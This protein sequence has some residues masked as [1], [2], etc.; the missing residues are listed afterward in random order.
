MAKPK[1]K[2]LRK[3][4]TSALA[5]E[6]ATHHSSA[7]GQSLEKREQLQTSAERFSVQESVNKEAIAPS[8]PITKLAKEPAIVELEPIAKSVEKQQPEVAGPIA[9]VAHQP[10]V[11]QPVAPTR[12]AQLQQAIE[13]KLMTFDQLAQEIG[14]QPHQDWTFK[15]PIS[16][17]T[18]T[19]RQRSTAY[20]EVETKLT[21]L[22]ATIDN[23]GKTGLSAFAANRPA[24]EKLLNDQLDE[25]SQA[26]NAYRAA[27]AKSTTKTTAIDN[28][29]KSIGDYKAMLKDGVDAVLADPSFD[30]VKDHINLEQ[31]LNAKKSGINFA[32]CKFDQY[33]DKKAAGADDKF[34]SGV[35]NSVAKIEYKSGESLVFK[36]EKT[37]ETFFE[38]LPIARDVGIDHNAPHYGN[39]NIASSAVADLL[40]SSVMPK[41]SYGLHKNPTSGEHEVGLLMTLAP[42]V[43]PLKTNDQGVKVRRELWKPDAP[44]SAVAQAKLQEQLAELD[45]CD[46]ITGQQ[47]RH[48]SNYMISIKGDNVVVTGIDNDVC[49]GALQGNASASKMDYFART[50]P[51]GLPPLIP[52]KIYDNLVAAD[53]DRDLMPKL[54]SLLTP[55]EVDAAR[56]RFNQVRAHALA[57]NP[58]FVV[59]DYQTWRSPGPAGVSSKQ[60]LKQAG[61]GVNATSSGGLFGRDFAAMFEKANIL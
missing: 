9:P 14:H 7:Q 32:D 33:N 2:K 30:R 46:V 54:T 37:S 28:M 45:W 18:V 22:L 52:K 39:R 20:K 1:P 6:S 44:P 8:K 29:L 15:N 43:T 40:G 17:E 5:E 50:T 26:A 11:Q 56:S 55:A 59:A 13:K 4:T 38:I 57:L 25:L 48:G 31:A 41:V 23:T 27:Q 61:N 10:V 3:P 34:G 51:P 12:P 16:G 58:H 19:V 47:D 24:T 21:T 35:A 53:F 42:G 60:Y 49:F 36:K